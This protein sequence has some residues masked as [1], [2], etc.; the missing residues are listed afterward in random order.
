MKSF[1]KFLLEGEVIPISRGRR[2]IKKVQRIKYGKVFEIQNNGEP[3]EPEKVI[4]YDDDNVTIIFV[5]GEKMPFTKQEL[6]GLFGSGLGFMTN[7]EFL[8]ENK[9]SEILKK[10][11][12]IGIPKSKAKHALIDMHNIFLEIEK[13]KG[14]TTGNK[15]FGNNKHENENRIR[16]A[17]ASREEL[18]RRLQ[19][20]RSKRE[21][22]NKP[23][24]ENKNPSGRP[25]HKQGVGGRGWKV[26][27][28]FWQNLL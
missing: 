5:N 17:K 23:S 7:E 24:I 10:F 8:E 22:E 28:S 15:T 1:G 4:F 3:H 25:L 20:N 11:A 6:K 18:E 12:K 21:K 13:N 14:K 16:Y 2:R 19:S 27:E 9:I 26:L